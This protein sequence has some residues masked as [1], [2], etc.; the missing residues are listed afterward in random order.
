MQTNDSNEQLKT[1]TTVGSGALLG[2]P[3]WNKSI[4][5]EIIAALWLIAALLAWQDNIK[6]LAW[7]LFLKSA[8]DFL[9]A[10]IYAIVEVILLKTAAD[11]SPNEKS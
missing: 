9:T 7:C 4:R 6:W 2:D 1:P 10:I 3:V 11:K 5:E 8:S